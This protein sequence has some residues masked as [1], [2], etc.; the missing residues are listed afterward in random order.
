[1]RRLPTV[2]L[3]LLCALPALAQLPCERLASLKL[4]GATITAS[5]RIAAGAYKTEEPPN[6]IVNVPAFCRVAAA[7]R[8]TADSSIGVEVWLPED[9]NGKYEAVGGGGWAGNISYPAMAAAVAEATLR[10]PPTRAI[11]AVTPNSRRGIRKRSWIT[12]TARFMK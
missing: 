3:S 11:R 4:A 2:S 12:H 8:P 7:L 9:W 6:A 1:M 10:P 5:D